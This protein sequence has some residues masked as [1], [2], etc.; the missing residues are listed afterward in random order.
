MATSMNLLIL[1]RRDKG[2]LQL[3]ESL[4]EDSDESSAPSSR[5][6]EIVSCMLKCFKHCHSI[7]CTITLQPS[8]VG[9]VKWSAVWLA[10]GWIFTIK[11]A[12]IQLYM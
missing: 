3:L 2:T 4:K 7:Y 8:Q 9:V 5:I 12:Y 6:N 11:M 10:C 1:F